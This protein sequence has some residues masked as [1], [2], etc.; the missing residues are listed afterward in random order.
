MLGVNTERALSWLSGND[1]NLRVDQF[2]IDLA[3]TTLFGKDEG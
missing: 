1:A 2:P 3:F